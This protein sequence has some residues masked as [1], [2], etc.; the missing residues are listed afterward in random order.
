MRVARLD[1]PGEHLRAFKVD[2][3]LTRERIS[4]HRIKAASTDYEIKASLLRIAI[5]C[6][7]YIRPWEA[8]YSS[9]R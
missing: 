4:E 1:E 6:N 7:S 9:Y 8:M 5:T 3:K 2:D